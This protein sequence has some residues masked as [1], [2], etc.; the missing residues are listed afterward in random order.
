[1]SAQELY[2]NPAGYVA[3]WNAAVDALVADKLMLPDDAV[4]Y[5]NR[6]LMQSVQPNFAKLG[7]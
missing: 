1:M 3:K 6:G 5:K 7:Q 4:M 2:T